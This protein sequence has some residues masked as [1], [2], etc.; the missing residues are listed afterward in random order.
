MALHKKAE[1]ISFVD[2]DGNPLPNIAGEQVWYIVY[3]G[4]ATDFFNAGG[5]PATVDLGLVSSTALGITDWFYGAL[6]AMTQ[7]SPVDGWEWTNIAS[8]ITGN[9]GSNTFSPL[10][11]TTVN[12]PV[13]TC[14][15]GG[16]GITY[17]VP[18]C[19][20]IADLQAQID[21]LAASEKYVVS[22]VIANPN[23]TNATLVLTMNDGST[24]SINLQAQIGA[25]DHGD[26]QKR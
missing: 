4:N 20:N 6:C 7:P 23:T 3:K 1:S 19:A 5:D 24:I 15:S 8:P 16:N 10:T 21:A 14:V 22:G 9:N 17:E 18:T 12:N 13:P 11:Q 25:K 26:T 2:C